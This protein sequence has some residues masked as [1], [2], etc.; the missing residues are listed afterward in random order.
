MRAGRMAA[1][2]NVKISLTLSEIF[3]FEDKAIKEYLMVIVPIAR[4][5]IIIQ[6]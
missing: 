4:K 1:G 2:M 6:K 3:I 5:N